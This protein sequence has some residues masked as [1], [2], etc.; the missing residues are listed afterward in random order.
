MRESVFA[1]RPGKR[2]RPGGCR[3]GVSTARP[4]EQ[5]FERLRKKS[6]RTKEI[7]KGAASAVPL[8][9]PLIR[10]LAPEGIL[11]GL[12]RGRYLL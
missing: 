1:A 7:G 12:R 4:D 5:G 11:A 9:R 10:A 3:G 2:R 8:R 6:V